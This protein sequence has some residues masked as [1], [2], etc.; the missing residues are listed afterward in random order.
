VVELSGPQVH[1]WRREGDVLHVLLNNP[2]LG[3]VEVLGE[4]FVSAGPG[5]FELGAPELREA[6]QDTRYI[7]LWE[8]PGARL[9]VEGVAGARELSPGEAPVPVMPGGTAA[10]L[11]LVEGPNARVRVTAAELPAVFDTQA[12]LDVVVDEKRAWMRA[13]FA[14]QPEQGRVYTARLEVPAGWALLGVQERNTGRGLSAERIG[15]GG[16]EVWHLKL[17]QAADAAHPLEFLAALRLQDESWT[18]AE[19]RTRALNFAAPMLAGTRRTRAHLGLRV[20]API[21]VTF[22]AMPAWRTENAAKLEALGVGGE[23]LRAGLA[24]ETPGAEVKLELARKLPRGQYDAVTHLLTLEDEAWVRC[25]LRLAVVDRG[26]DEVVVVLPPEAKEPLNIRGPEIKEIAAGGAP[27]QRRIRFEQPWLGLRILRVE[28]RAALAADRDAPVPEVRLEGNFD[29]R[30]RIV[31][32]SAGAV[33]VVPPAPGP[34]LAAAS[35]DD[36]PEFAQPFRLGRALYAFTFR[37]EGA[38]GTFRTHVF[39]R[40]KVLSS[41]VRTLDLATVLDASG[42]SRTHAAF[43]LS[44][45]REQ[46]LPLQLPG[47]AQLVDVAVNGE[48]VRPVRGGEAGAF[49]IPLPPRTFAEVELVYERRRKTLGA[50]GT[51]REAGPELTGLAVGETRWR[52]YH[53]PSYRLAVTGGN[54]EPGAREEPE[55]FALSFWRRLLTLSWPRWTAWEAWGEAPPARWE[56]PSRAG[57][58]EPRQ[59]RPAQGL[60]SVEARQA[61]KQKDTV[62][63]AGVPAIPEGVL[64][65]GAKLGGAPV[66][67]VAYRER[68]YARFAMRAAFLLAVLAGLWLATNVSRR[69]ALGYVVAGLLAGTLVPPALGWL[70]PLLGVPFCEGLT[71]CAL[72]ALAVAAWRGAAWLRRRG[73]GAAP[74]KAVAALLI[75]ALLAAALSARA[76]EDAGQARTPATT[77]TGEASDPVLIPY[78]PSQVL[79]PDADPRARQVYVPRGRFLELMALAHPEKKEEPDLPKLAGA[80]QPVR[81]ALGNAEY[82]LTAGEKTWHARG[83]LD[84]RTFDPK[85]WAK[86][87]LAYSPLQL[88]SVTLD[89]RPAAVAHEAPAPPASKGKGAASEAGVPFLPLQGE[90]KHRVEVTLEGPL[91]LSPGRARLNTRL[92][93]GAATRLVA[94]LPPGVELD[95]KSLPPGAWI[96]KPAAE[97]GPVRCELNL[98]AGGD[99]AL[100]WHAADIRVRA[101]AQLAAR[102]F[103]RFTLS[104]DGYP[105]YRAEQVN[106]E[107]AGVDALSY[108]LLGR[109]EIANV[110]AAD[111]SEWAVTGEGAARRLRLWFQKPVN[112]VLIQMSGWA[113]LGAEAAPAALLSLEGAVRQ[114][115][116]IGLQHGE[117]RRF[118]VSSLAGLPRASHA[119]L[120]AMFKLPAESLPDRIYQFHEP[121]AAQTVGA[122]WESG[123]TA[124]ETRIVGV[125]RPE[126]LL[127]CVQ[128]KYVAGERMP[129]RHEVEL[130]ADWSVRTVRG[131]AL[132]A[133]EVQAAGGKQRLVVH[134]DARA[135]PGTEVT[136]SAEQPLT[137]PAAGPLTLDLPSPRALGDAKQQETVDW[138]LAADQGLA[139]AEG[140]GTTMRPLPLD[141]A[142]AWVRPEES[143][144]Y[145][146]AFRSAKPDSRLAVEVSRRESMGSCI[147]V[148]F[149]QAG[150]D[151]VQVNAHA[152]FQLELSGRDR[153][154]LKLPAGAQLVSLAARNLRSRDVE[155][156][157]AGVFVNVLLQSAVRGAQELE[158]VYRLARKAGQDVVVS[159]PQAED[160]AIKRET[161]YVGLMQREQGLVTLAAPQG[162]GRKLDPEELPAVPAEVSVAA[163]AEAYAAE[164]GWS[165]TLRQPATTKDTG[166]DVEVV[167]AEL[168][169]V[170]AADGV[171]RSVATYTVRN[172]A[173]Q[174]LRAALPPDAALWGVLV[175]GK[176][177]TVSQ[178]PEQGRQVLRIPIQRLSATDL[179]LKVALFYESARAALPALACRFVPQAPELLE[180]SVSETVWQVYVP[181]E[182]ELTRTGGTV[183]EVVGS[184]RIGSR[185]K[186]NVAEAKRLLDIQETASSPSAQR[187]AL[188]NL[189]RYQLELSDNATQLDRLGQAGQMANRDEQQR[190]DPRELQGQ[191]GLNR[192][193]QDDA[194]EV[195]KRLQGLTKQMEQAAG[196]AEADARRAVLDAYNFQE[197]RWRGG[198][199]YKEARPERPPVPAGEAPLASLLSRQPFA[200]FGRGALSGPARP[201][202]DTETKVLPPEPGWREDLERGVQGLPAGAEL[203]VPTS[204][205]SYTFRCVEDRP[206]LTVMLRSRPA[207]WHWAARM[208]LIVLA[209][210]TWFVLRRKA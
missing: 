80:A 29:A 101:T 73:R 190:I 185:V 208:T 192:R 169:T 45:S 156:T 206:E 25:D 67:E 64:L 178:A 210:A 7:A 70:S 66:F 119:E 97:G 79:T 37:A 72:A 47:D 201:R 35:L 12:A 20:A 21:D 113:S 175:D 102:S 85:G 27:G 81:V 22:G 68:S 14:L 183:S 161:H 109:W 75:L 49:A 111:L 165:V 48:S 194:Q 209:L 103:T 58:G 138:V 86:L 78:P 171:V 95:R 195:Q 69:A 188:G 57:A 134:F 133:W 116:F 13:V 4:G 204:G 74:A 202:V 19:W 40:S 9:A 18:E 106:I 207:T 141:R 180:T 136:W 50:F 177:A 56:A 115:G 104:A 199:N 166:P 144:E 39:E 110:T 44:Y 118:T 139:L 87:P 92:V 205:R 151:H 121:P 43:L 176:P 114:A 197:N 186:S 126:R 131:N 123:Q 122:E 149:V 154:R 160:A 129:W 28:Y 105:V 62:R 182:Y 41:V 17:D 15:S 53:P 157:P 162:L 130:P 59:A 10:R 198:K 120:A 90:G 174:F 38:P 93:G 155:E 164:R 140:A 5:A 168:E 173:R 108:Q 88:V 32:Q 179:P 117:G 52:L 84:V 167:L 132:R 196:A 77:A 71:L 36:T 1:S 31:F 6:Q 24:T 124:L 34:G 135:T 89:G 203:R 147:V 150:E 82:E 187:R 2:A 100:S 63:V 152:R 16:A 200:G 55:Y 145:R 42:V 107:G 3:E 96:E 91:E 191:L 181:E 142:P 60:Q 158:L 76:Q 30:R 11:F 159:G 54:V 94:I 8:P 26:V 184:L 170:L 33:E 51:W 61:E 127:A 112:E 163:L 153:L 146:F 23:M 137:L 99:V 46:Y 189:Q 65:E 193:Y 98:G 172:R 125:V 143:D 148:S 128:T 83:T